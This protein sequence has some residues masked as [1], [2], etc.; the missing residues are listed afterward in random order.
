MRVFLFCLLLVCSLGWYV[1]FAGAAVGREV[2]R[3][4]GGAPES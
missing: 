4:A 1:T 3:S 2:R